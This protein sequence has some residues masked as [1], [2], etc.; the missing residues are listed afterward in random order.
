M[1]DARAFSAFP[2]SGLRI[3]RQCLCFPPE[4]WQPHPPP[5]LARQVTAGSALPPAE[6][7]NTDSRFDSFADPQCG[8]LV[9]FHRLER[10]ST[11][12][13]FWHFPQ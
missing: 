2:A 6:D 7:A 5:P 9:P 4:Q 8:H 10:T 13:S 3:C 12:L 11:S 1:V